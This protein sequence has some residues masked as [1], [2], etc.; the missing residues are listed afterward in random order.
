MGFRELAISNC[1]N[2][3]DVRFWGLEFMDVQQQ[4]VDNGTILSYAAM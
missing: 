2:I 3:P 1:T 4:N